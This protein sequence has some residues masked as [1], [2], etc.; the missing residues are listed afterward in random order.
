MKSNQ[1]SIHINQNREDQ[2]HQREAVNDGVFNWKLI[3]TYL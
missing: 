3:K 2:R 1:K